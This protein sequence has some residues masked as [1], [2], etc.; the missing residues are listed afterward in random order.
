MPFPTCALCFVIQVPSFLLL[1][2]CLPL[3]AMALLH[4]HGLT[5]ETMGPNKPSLLGA[6]LATAFIIATEEN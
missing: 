6:A 2:P 3:G 4:Y 1:L 5:P